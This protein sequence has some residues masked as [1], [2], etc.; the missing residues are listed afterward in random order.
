MNSNIGFPIPQ[1]GEN[2]QSPIVYVQENTTWGYRS[3]VRN[4][5]KEKAPGEEELNAFGSEGWELAGVFADLPFV[6]FYFKRMTGG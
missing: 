3:L 5:S 4:L 6:Y 1:Q 2:L